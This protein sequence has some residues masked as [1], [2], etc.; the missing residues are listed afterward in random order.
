M[1]RLSYRY[2]DSVLVNRDSV[3]YIKYSLFETIYE[4]LAKHT[5]EE[6]RISFASKT[7]TY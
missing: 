7:L 4:E 1:L 3:L 5:E 6:T 2:L